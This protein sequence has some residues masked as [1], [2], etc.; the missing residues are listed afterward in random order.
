MKTFKWLWHLLFDA[1]SLVWRTA[2]AVHISVDWSPHIGVNVGGFFRFSPAYTVTLDDGDEPY[3]QGAALRLG[4]TLIW[5]DFGLAIPNDDHPDD[6]VVVS[7]RYCPT[8]GLEIE[9]RFVDF[10]TG[11][12]E[13]ATSCACVKRDCCIDSGTA[14]AASCCRWDI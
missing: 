14:D 1:R 11:C 12:S 13:L 9:F 7:P 10:C 6:E 8:C 2:R 5:L 4:L 3:S